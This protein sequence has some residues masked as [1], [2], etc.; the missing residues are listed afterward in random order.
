MAGNPQSTNYSTEIENLGITGY[1]RGQ[2]AF[3]TNSGGFVPLAALLQ[4]FTISPDD[5]TN[6]MTN[7]RSQ[8]PSRP[9]GGGSGG[10]GGSSGGSERA[11]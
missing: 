2:H 4:R 9:S 3:K 7:W 10:G 11:S 8:N 1:D 5:V 6:A